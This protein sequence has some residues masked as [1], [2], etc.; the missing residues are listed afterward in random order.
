MSQDR[1]PRYRVY[2]LDGVLRIVN[3]EWVDAESDEEAIA[4]V[5]STCG[6]LKCEIWDGDRLVAS[7]APERLQA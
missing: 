6:G 7:I 4:I 5:Q 1:N 2:T 3:A